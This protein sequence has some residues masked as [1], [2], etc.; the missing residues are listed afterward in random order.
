MKNSTKIKKPE[1]HLP[2]KQLTPAIIG[3]RRIEGSLLNLKRAAKVC[4]ANEQKKLSPDNALISVL[5]DTVRLVREQEDRMKENMKGLK[6][7][8]FGG[9]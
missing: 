7:R 9:G 2:P 6:K 8:V 4:I 1:E 3:G 5:C